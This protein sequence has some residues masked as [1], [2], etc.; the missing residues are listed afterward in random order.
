MEKD[1]PG[2]KILQRKKAYRS[3]KVRDSTYALINNLSGLLG[4]RKSS[5]VFAG[6]FILYCLIEN[7]LDLVEK[8]LMSLKTKYLR[9]VD[10]IE[11]MEENLEETLK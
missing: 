2:K 5:V 4:I 7:R 9:A 10:A 6:V 11:R 8:V 3:V 1:T